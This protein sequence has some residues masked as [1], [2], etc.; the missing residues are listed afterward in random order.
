M[1]V[2]LIWNTASTDLTNT[3][4]GAEEG[5]GEEAATCHIV[6]LQSNTAKHTAVQH[7]HGHGLTGDCVRFYLVQVCLHQPMSSR[8]TSINGPDCGRIC[9]IILCACA[10]VED[11][12][13]SLLRFVPVCGSVFG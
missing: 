11:V 4:I 12:R 7:T 9:A 5:E 6:P 10:H 2:Y 8:N 3:S 1:N 13:A